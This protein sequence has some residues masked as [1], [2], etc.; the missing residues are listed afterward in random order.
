MYFLEF[1]MDP[2]SVM[3][4]VV[5]LLAGAGKVATVLRKL[6]TSVVDAPV[7]IGLLLFQIEDISNCLSAVKL[8]LLE[9]NS[10]PKRRVSMVQV[11]HLVATLTEAVL[12]FSELEAVIIPLKDIN[13]SAVST[14]QRLKWAWEEENMANIMTRLDRHKSSLSLIL[15]ILQWCV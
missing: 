13:V 3:A 5:G 11:D 2:L 15:N 12:T 14:I 7:S 10:A 1:V 4:S 9:I 8:L 6:K